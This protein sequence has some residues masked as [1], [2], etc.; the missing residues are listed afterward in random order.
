MTSRT[1]PCKADWGSLFRGGR[2]DGQG[3]WTT[4]VDNRDQQAGFDTDGDRWAVLCE[5]HSTILSVHRLDV[6]RSVTVEDFCGY[7]RGDET[8]LWDDIEHPA[9]TV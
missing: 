1:H 7:C 9:R 4:V 8:Y 6:A 2:R 3:R 5:T